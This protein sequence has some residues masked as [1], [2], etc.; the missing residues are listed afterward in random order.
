MVKNLLKVIRVLKGL[1]QAD[2]LRMLNIYGLQSSKISHWQCENYQLIWGL[3]KLLCSWF[4]CRILAQN[5]LW[6]NSFCGF[7][8]QSRGNTV[9]QLLMTSFK[10]LPVNHISS[11]RSYPEMNHGSTAM[12]QKWRPS[13]SNGRRLILH[14][15]RR[16][17]KI[18]QYQDHNCVFLLGRC[19]PSKIHPSRSNN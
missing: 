18:Q 5:M 1:Q 9:L 2:H 19:C 3:Q 14:A 7:C 12:M 10:L 17:S 6:Q 11:R 4:L 8:Y 13:H 16:H 15:Q